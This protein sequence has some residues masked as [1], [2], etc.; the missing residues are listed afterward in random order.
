MIEETIRERIMKLLMETNCPLSAKE[1]IVELGL[2]P[3]TREREIY[4]HIEHIAK[5]IRRK[6]RGKYAVFMTPPQ[7]KS[8]GYVFKNLE[9]PRRPSKCPRCRSQRI[10]PPRFKIME[11]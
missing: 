3:N 10:E 8:C 9:K 11:V 2:D 7:C 6:S 5:T 4:E 1:I